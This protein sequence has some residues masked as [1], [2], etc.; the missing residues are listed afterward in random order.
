LDYAR[1]HNIHVLCYPAHSTHVYQGLDVVV[2]SPLKHS[3]TE[4][5]DNFEGSTRQRITKQNFVSIYGRAHRKVL[6]PE[7][8][9]MA[10]E[11]TG[12]WPYNPNV[13][14]KEMMAPSLETS[15]QG[16]LPLFQPSPVRAVSSMMRQYQKLHRNFQEASPLTPSPTP[17]SSITLLH[18]THNSDEPF[19]GTV[20]SNSNAMPRRLETDHV[21]RPQWYAATREVMQDLDS[22][23]AGPSNS[24]TMPPHFETNRICQPQWH[25]VAREAME[26]LESTSASFL[27]SN[28]P[29]TSSQRLPEYRPSTLTPT[30]KRKHVLLEETPQ[31]ER[32]HAYQS[33]LQD[34]YSRLA[35]QKKALFGMQ[36]T[37][38]LHSMYCD[39]VSEQLAA[40]EDKQKKRKT[41]QLNGD[42]LPRLLTG[43]EF[44]KQVVEHEAAAEEEKVER[45]NRRKLKEAQSGVMAAWKE[46]DNTRKQRNKDQR[47]TYH[48]ELRLWEVERNLAKQE[49]RRT[50]WAKP[51]LGKLEAPAP[52][53]V[54]ESG[55]GDGEDE[56]DDGNGESDGGDGEE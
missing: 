28:T 17:A 7:L 56:E 13:V 2:F 40:Q 45:E 44:H 4:E 5:R 36:S 34:A 27:T 16:H 3:W 42:G 52:R 9:R 12:I 23:G 30:R 53:L 39:N 20:P 51:K 41:G 46:A 15:S 54:V 25:T 38:V 33:A 43:D 1:D 35:L 18:Q 6:T 11:K 48:E 21:R 47:S 29:L 14:T 10:F 8:V 31:N 22:P 24:D 55:D 19:T 37:T 49:K 26:D 50:G 32:E